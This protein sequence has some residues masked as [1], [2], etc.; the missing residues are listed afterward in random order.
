MQETELFDALLGLYAYDTGCVDSG[1]HD[2]LLRE[3]V[4]NE[5]D[6]IIKD[7]RKEYQ[8]VSDRFSKTI[9]QFILLNFLDDNSISM[10]YGYEDML[11]FLEWL[12]NNM[13]V[14]K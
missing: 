5:L 2:E 10:G 6:I 7:N 14:P 13:G 12:T 4:I 11:E 1:I 9:R 8:L 3:R